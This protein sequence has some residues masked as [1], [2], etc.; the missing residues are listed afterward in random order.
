MIL[1]EKTYFKVH[2]SL[3][4][5]NHVRLGCR[6]QRYDVINRGAMLDE[7][8]QD[9]DRPIDGGEEMGGVSDVLYPQWP[10]HFLF[11][12]SESSNQKSR[13]RFLF[14]PCVKKN[15]KQP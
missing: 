15:K 4:D 10:V 5:T 7:V 1:H 3:V 13:L 11:L 6:S 2:C 14:R 8:D 12:Q 9:V